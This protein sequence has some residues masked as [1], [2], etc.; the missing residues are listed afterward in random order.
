MCDVVLELPAQGRSATERALGRS[1]VTA[2]EASPLLR[3]PGM[4]NYWSYAGG[5][6]LPRSE[7]L[8]SPPPAH[9]VGGPRRW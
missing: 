3:L 7:G 4:Y 9:R 2:V 6:I 1:D 5:F 8:S